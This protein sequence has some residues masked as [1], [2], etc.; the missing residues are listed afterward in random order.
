MAVGQISISPEFFKKERYSA[1]SDWQEAFW[2]ENFQNSIDAGAR[3]ITVR[4]TEIE[5]RLVRVEFFDDGCGMTRQVLDEVYFDLGA[6]T[7]TGDST[8]GGF[9]RARMLTCFGM[10]RYAIATLDN[11][12][13]GRGSHYEIAQGDFVQGCQ[14]II[15]VDATTKEDL[16]AALSKYLQKC[17]PQ[18]CKVLVNAQEWVS[19]TPRGRQ[20]RELFLD[21]TDGDNQLSRELFAKVFVTKKCEE[22]RVIVRV[23]GAAMFSLATRARAL[24]VV[25]LE[26]P[27][28]RKVLTSNRDGL[29]YRYRRVLD[30]FLEELAVDTTSSL[31]PRFSNKSTVFE[32]AGWIMASAFV[33]DEIGGEDRSDGQKIAGVV[34]LRHEPAPHDPSQSYQVV[35][36]GDRTAPESLEGQCFAKKL[37]YLRIDVDTENPAVHRSI[38]RYDPKNWV[39]V[40]GR[41]GKLV[42]NGGDIYKIMR[43]WAVCVR[44]AVKALLRARADT[45]TFYYGVGWVFSDETQASC[46]GSSQYKSFLL[47]PVDADGNLKFQLSSR[48]SLKRMM[49]YAKHEAAHVLERWHDEGYAR[50]LTEVDAHFDERQV[51]AEINRE[52]RGC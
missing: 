13:E 47:N 20:A 43:A 9:G 18:R 38:P 24:V 1:Y 49:A 10:A 21:D 33:Q 36:G 32:G 48:D 30:A 41:D 26:P 19:W 44:E 31:K 15:D 7:K 25:E 8:V 22:P 39:W 37:P 4:T 11:R 17:Q 3:T 51:V 40:K 45:E 29:V 12:V 23:H 46:T 52:V 2:R 27:L 5:P 14:L 35:L 42:R 34:A 28:A 16:D 6:S 50:L